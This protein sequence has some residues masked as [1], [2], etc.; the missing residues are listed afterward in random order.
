MRYEIDCE[1]AES[2]YDFIGG[3]N[4]SG[5]KD[6]N[7]VM[8]RLTSNGFTV[9]YDTDNS[10]ADSADKLVL[11]SPQGKS[12]IGYTIDSIPGALN[13]PDMTKMA[14]KQVSRKSP[15][16]FFLMVEGGNIDHAAHANDGGTVIKEIVAF[17]DAIKV[18]YDFY[19]SHPDET[20]IV[21]TADHDTGG[22]ALNG[23]V[24]LGMADYQRMSKDAM[25]DYFREMIKNGT[26]V[27]WAEMKDFLKAKLG[28]WTSVKVN[29]AQNEMLEKAFEK[30]FVAREGKDE[31]GLYNSFDEFVN[32]VFDVMNHRIGTHFTTRSHSANP[33]PVFAIGKGSELF[34]TVMN[35]TEIPV[36]ILKATR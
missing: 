36:K 29:D 26:P 19:L 21:V 2:G 23:K 30:T 16:R 14:L 31:K 32:K 4:L 17:Q 25:S 3:A 11:L 33:V 35:N 12:D 15:D 27:S 34:G 7:D 24:N 9:V 20:L 5:M 13:L 10:A 8:K 18:A 22:M 1:A 6:D 28:F